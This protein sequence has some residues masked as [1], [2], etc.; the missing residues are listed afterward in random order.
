MGL[1]LY[2]YMFYIGG[3]WLPL[4]F[5]PHNNAFSMI[6]SYYRCTSYIINP[7]F[8]PSLLD[9]LLWYPF[10]GDAHM[11]PTDL[12]LHVHSLLKS[13]FLF[14]WDVSKLPASS[15]L[16]SPVRVKYENWIKEA[17]INWLSQITKSLTSPRFKPRTSRSNTW[18]IGPQVHRALLMKI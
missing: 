8:S 5:I 4:L 6:T 2:L 11:P 3:F 18:R 7:F 16:A 9:Q 10:N 12:F 15:S 17:N 1:C 13:L 14:K